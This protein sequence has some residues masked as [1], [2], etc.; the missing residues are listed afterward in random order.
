MENT[1]PNN[2]D[3][4]DFIKN[5][6]SKETLNAVCVNNK[7]YLKQKDILEYKEV[8]KIIPGNST[9]FDIQ[10]HYQHLLE[11]LYEEFLSRHNEFKIIKSRVNNLDYSIKLTLE[12]IVYEP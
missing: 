10:V 3:V 2:N 7:W 5:Q 9:N 12:A 11:I 1:N 6:T 4:Q 8:S